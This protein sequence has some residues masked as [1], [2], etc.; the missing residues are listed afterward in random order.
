M[1]PYNQNQPLNQGNQPF[2]Q[3]MRN[4]N[5]SQNQSQNAA[6]LDFNRISE[7]PSKYPRQ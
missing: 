3:N 1:Q 5:V 4:N 2:N 6:L 7:L